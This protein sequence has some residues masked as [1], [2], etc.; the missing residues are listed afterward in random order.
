AGQAK[1]PTSAGAFGHVYL[2][3]E[4]DPAA[5]LDLCGCASLEISL[6][7]P[8]EAPAQ[9]P[10][11]GAVLFELRL[12]GAALP[13]QL[14]HIPEHLDPEQEP[15]DLVTGPLPLQGGRG[16]HHAASSI[17]RASAGGATSSPASAGFDSIRAND[18]SAARAAS[19]ASA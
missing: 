2:C 16:R 17:A 11:L 15:V 4:V 6:D 9:A 3:G 7:E 8:R 1:A 13:K 19:P 12:A 14:S 5:A 10:E 18:S